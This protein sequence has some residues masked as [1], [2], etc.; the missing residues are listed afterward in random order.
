[1][2]EGDIKV[3]VGEGRKVVILFGAVYDLTGYYDRH[4]GGKKV[5]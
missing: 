2:G 1:L 4:P 3:M 5:I